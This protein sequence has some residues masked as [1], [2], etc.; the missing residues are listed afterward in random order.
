MVRSSL[1][2][3]LCFGPALLFIVLA[4]A[5]T[6]LS[7]EAKAAEN[8][9][10]QARPP[11]PGIIPRPKNLPDGRRWQVIASQ[12]RGVINCFDLSRDGKWAAYADDANVRVC[13]VQGFALRH[14]LVGHMGRVRAIAFSPDGSRIATGSDDATAV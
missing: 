7:A 14:F 2:R 10:Q 9:S 12:P 8:P 1:R 5:G 4:V 11:L 13:E 6:E 3:P